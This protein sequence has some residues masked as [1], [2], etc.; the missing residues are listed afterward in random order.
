MR[1]SGLFLALL[2]LSLVALPGCDS[3]SPGGE[4][5]PPPGAESVTVS[6]EAVNESGT[7]IDTAAIIFDGT[8]VGTGYAEETYEQDPDGTVTIEADATGLVS[9]DSSVG[10]GSD[11]N[12][13]L[14][15]REELPDEAT[16][17]FS[18]TTVD[19]DSSASG[20]WTWSDEQIADGVASGEHT[21]P[22]SEQ[23]RQLC[24]EEG[25]FFLQTCREITPNQDRSVEL[26]IQRKQVT[27]TVTPVDS[28]GAVR[29]ETVTKV[30][31]PNQSDS[32]EINGEKSTQLPKRSGDRELF[33]DLITK[34]P[35]SDKRDRFQATDT[36]SADENVSLKVVL[37]K[38]DACSDGIDNEANGGDGLIDEEDPGCANDAGTGYDP[39]DDNEN[40]YSSQITVGVV[41][42]DSTFVSGQ[43]SQR[44]VKI[45]SSDLPESVTVAIGEIPLWIENK[46]LAVSKQ[47]FLMEIQSAEFGPNGCTNDYTASQQSEVVADPDTATGFA[48]NRVYGLTRD[49]FDGGRCYKLKAHKAEP[50]GGSENKGLFSVGLEEIRSSALRWFFEDDHPD[51]QGN[52]KV[53]QLSQLTTLK[54]GECRS[55]EDG[56]ICKDISGKT[57]P[58][59]KH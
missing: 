17:S 13:E 49:A 24:V 2:V 11:H 3:G 10:L 25:E 40:H 32:S 56:K 45:W 57:L 38:L 35:D 12:L 23:S 37:V 1:I 4:G 55:V 6:A 36:F 48:V 44:S 47:H 5:D 27:V 59:M 19:S 53:L 14:T 41:H 30:Y 46:R 8:Q 42:D 29:P 21:V 34:E 7:R 22:G 39:D 33:S 58:Q 26:E 52:S 51:L 16:I 9:A 50:Y 54:T 15:L 20:T 28:T 43:K 18:N 31:E